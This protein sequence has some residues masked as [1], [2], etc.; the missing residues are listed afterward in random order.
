MSLI[1]V[2]YVF[3]DYKVAMTRPGWGMCCDG[4]H[5]KGHI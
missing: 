3:K 1:E 4:R 2:S 5:G